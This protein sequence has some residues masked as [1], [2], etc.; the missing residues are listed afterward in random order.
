MELPLGL[1]IN[2]FYGANQQTGIGELDINEKAI[3]K[4]TWGGKLTLEFSPKSI[5]GYNL[6]VNSGYIDNISE[7]RETQFM[8]SLDGF[9]DM[10]DVIIHPELGYGYYTQP[11]GEYNGDSAYFNPRCCGEAYNSGINEIVNI[12]IDIKKNVIGIPIK[13]QIYSLGPAIINRNASFVNTSTHN[14]AD[15]YVRSNVDWDVNYRRAAFTHVHQ[16]ANNRRGF[17]LAAD[18]DIGKFKVGLRTN[19]GTEIENKHDVV[20]FEHKLN[21]QSR[22][23]FNFWDAQS[24]P[25]GRLLY[26]YMQLF[27][28]LPITD[29]LSDYNKTFNVTDLD[30]RYKTELFGRGFIVTNYTSYQSVADHYSPVPY[31]TDAAFVRVVYNE[32]LSY[33]NLSKEVTLIGHFGY[34][35]AWGNDRTE[36]SPENGQPINQ[37]SWA[38]GLG[39]DWNFYDNM[40]LY[41][42][43]LWM[44]HEDKNFV[45]DKFRG[46][47]TTFELKVFF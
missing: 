26:Q 37:T 27:E 45:L 46:W 13:A 30:I 24:G 32:L 38:T 18:K 19:V 16:L 10:G 4:K 41:L 35:R 14:N 34:H 25:Y 1:G 22:A 3:T 23:G 15:D 40:G 28:T 9:F 17:I 11:Y 36:L 12:E 8:N 5:I 21:G 44:G 7:E 20:T 33:F 42:R 39:I 31:F 43:Q 47:E 2:F 29:T 6:F